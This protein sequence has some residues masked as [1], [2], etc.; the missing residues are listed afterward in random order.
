MQG[1]AYIIGGIMVGYRSKESYINKF[2]DIE[3]QER[4]NKVVVERKKRESRKTRIT[5]KQAYDEDDI[6]SGDAIRCMEC[7][8]I[9]T[10]LQWTHFKYK[11][12][13]NIL[14]IIEY[15]KK[16][17][18]SVIAPNLLQKTK[19]TLDNMIA[20]YGKIEG[21]V[22]WKSYCDKQA[23]SN[24]IDYKT[25]KYG[26]DQQNFDDYNKSR[27][28][29]LINFIKRHGDSAGLN[30]WNQYC[31][32][33]SFTNTLDYF[34]EREGSIEKGLET[35]KS[36]NKEKASAHDPYCIADKYNITLD[37]ALEL[38][39]E[40]YSGNFVSEGEKA[41]VDD[42]ELQYGYSFPYTYKTKQF[43]LWSAELNSPVFYDMVDTNNKLII[44]YYGDYW[45][46]NPKKY[47]SDFIVKQSGMT[48]K[49]IW[50]HDQ[51]KN[52][53]AMNRG[54]KVI[55][56]WESDYLNGNI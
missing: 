33:Q 20:I 4:Y 1:P 18:A 17:Q 49:E 21:L 2:G 19:I 16:H 25:E 38:L 47:A 48:A 55:I 6:N 44:E 36:I 51:I 41:F 7:G 40:R 27:S 5:N 29:T 15:K 42:M 35:Y 52:L 24:M 43:C 31:E 8:F 56:V 13:G 11:C 34:I 28:S 3:G 32:R 45:H 14:S 9:T 26:W 30:K 23:K 53:T 39:S 22:K 37:A 12:S 50:E 10:R 54:F 46:A